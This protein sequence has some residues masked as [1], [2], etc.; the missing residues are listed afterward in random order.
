MLIGVVAILREVV[1]LTLYVNQDIRCE[2]ESGV[3]STSVSE[4]IDELNKEYLKLY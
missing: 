2:N 4:A 1:S 3:V